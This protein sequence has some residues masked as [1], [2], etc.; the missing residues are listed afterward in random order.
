MI[1]RPPRSTL[2]SSSAA[3]D[4]YKRQGRDLVPV[5]KEYKASEEASS[6][7]PSARSICTAPPFPQDMDTCV[8]DP[9]NFW[10]WLS[11]NEEALTRGAALNLFEG[12]PDKEFEVVVTGGGTGGPTR[13]EYETCLLYTSPSPRDS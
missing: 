4:V 13:F 5:V 6:M 12:H 2:S 7:Q 8:P 9:F 10:D 1:R 11:A 3:S